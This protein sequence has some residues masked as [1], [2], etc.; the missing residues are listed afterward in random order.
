V[1]LS[2][3]STPFLPF[4]SLSYPLL[5]CAERVVFL[6]LLYHLVLS[7][8]HQKRPCTQS[9]ARA[10]FLPCLSLSIFFQVLHLWSPLFS[11]Q[12]RLLLAQP[13]SCSMKAMQEGIRTEGVLTYL[14]S[15][16]SFLCSFCRYKSEGGR[17][18][19]CSV[20]FTVDR[21]CVCTMHR[22][23]IRTYL[24]GHKGKVSKPPKQV[25]AVIVE[26]RITH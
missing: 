5:P 19:M 24:Q 18:A 4:H 11:H 14:S 15:F 6:F 10:A 1:S 26:H 21:E 16:S 13:C 23:S 22:C 17:A 7:P 12:C 2:S 8:T 20:A 3:L 25:L 9:T